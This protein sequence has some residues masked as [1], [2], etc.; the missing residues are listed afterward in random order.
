LETVDLKLEL[1]GELD[2]LAPPETPLASNSSFIPP[3]HIA[4]ATKPQ[5]KYWACTF[6][7]LSLSWDW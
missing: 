3:T 4:Q 5:K 7:D 6:L 2:R 1:F